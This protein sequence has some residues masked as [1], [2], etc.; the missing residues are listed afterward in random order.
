LAKVAS[1][2]AEQSALVVSGIRLTAADAERDLN[3]RLDLILEIRRVET[4]RGIYRHV[5][6]F[7]FLGRTDHRE[8]VWAA[9]CVV[10]RNGLSYCEDFSFTAGVHQ[11]GEHHRRNI[12]DEVPGRACFHDAG[13]AKRLALKV[14]QAHQSIEALSLAWS[15]LSR[16]FTVFR[17]RTARGNARQ[18][19][20]VEPVKSGAGLHL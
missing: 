3:S 1:K 17:F 8:P 15:G 13:D 20:L 11:Q 16:V 12:V 5:F 19:N 2:Q 14:L 10:I 18:L 4:V 6:T 9:A 7:G